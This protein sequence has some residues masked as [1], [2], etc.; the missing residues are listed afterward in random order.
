MTAAAPQDKV[1]RGVSRARQGGGGLLRDGSRR[2]WSRNE[3]A[4]RIAI[5]FL[6][7]KRLRERSWSD[8]HTWPGYRDGDD[9]GGAALQLLAAAAAAAA[10]FT[11]Q[12]PHGALIHHHHHSHCLDEARGNESPQHHSLAPR[13]CAPPLLD[14]LPSLSLPRSSLV[15]ASSRTSKPSRESSSREW[16]AT[17]AELELDN[18][19]AQVSCSEYTRGPG[20]GC[21]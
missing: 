21:R 15:L 12:R 7:Y 1:H 2:L 6:L 5:P 19:S 17:R 16:R 8:E 9:D 4:I 14:A 20:R 13:S 3:R 18:I 11:S 10:S